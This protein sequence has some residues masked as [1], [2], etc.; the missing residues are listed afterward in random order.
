MYRKAWLKVVYSIS[1]ILFSVF[2]NN[3]LKEVHKQVEL[4]IQIRQN[5][6][7]NDVY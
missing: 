5:N 4:G 2:I 1:S 7:R 6:R 3:F